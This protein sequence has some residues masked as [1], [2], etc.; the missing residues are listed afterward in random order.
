MVE[1]MWK[2]ICLLW[3][4]SVCLPVGAIDLPTSAPIQRTFSVDTSFS[5][6][7]FYNYQLID[8][9]FEKGDWDNLSFNHSASSFESIT[10]LLHI[11][12]DIPKSDYLGAHYDLSMHRNTSRCMTW[13][14]G[15]G[16]RDFVSVDVEIDGVFQP[17]TELAVSI[18]GGALSFSSAGRT[19]LRAE[20]RVRLNFDPIDVGLD[21]VCRGIVSMTVELQL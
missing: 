5:D 21:K 14:G 9:S 7:E 10:D 16:S 17:V 6:A 19:G 18:G 3:A 15:V 8:V 4:L 20:H 11:T 2:I 1:H 12:T 13:T